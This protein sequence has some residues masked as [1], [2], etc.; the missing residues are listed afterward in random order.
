[1]KVLILSCNTGE[2][3]N[4]SAKAIKKYMDAQ[5]IECDFED[6]LGLVSE[7]VS[8]SV[9]DIYVFSTKSS[10]FE[11]AYRIGAFVSDMET[12]LKS[13]VYITNK[14][15][16]K[17]LYDYIVSGGYDAV[18]CVHLFPAEALT[19]LKRNAKLKVPAIF[20]ATDYTVY[21]LMHETMLDRYVIPHEDLIEDW[22][23][24]GIPR[25]KL[26]PIGIAVDEA[27][28]TERVPKSEARK[29]C[30]EVF[31]WRGCENPD[32]R[33]Y[34]VM[35]GS[36]GFGDLGGLIAELRSLIEEN[37]RVVCVCGR[38]EKVREKLVEEFG[39]KI[40]AIGFT[41]K[42]SMLMDACDVLF[43]KPGGIT[44]TEAIIKNIPFIH[45][46]PIPGLEDYNARFFHY[47][48]MSYSTT[49]VE[50]QARVAVR[51]T[52]DEAYRQRM[53]D[54]QIRNSNPHTCEQIT[55]LVEEM[56]EATSRS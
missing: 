49:D 8:K 13:P 54:A 44:S 50:Q 22:V 19:A 1:M 29:A 36:M 21:P 14:L 34:L 41:D 32:S 11:R 37:D 56:V 25:E 20:V 42:V 9:S 10:L 16:A 38:N 5:G 48:N 18:I 31:G 52:H 7:T 47:H 15:Y 26:V 27:K 35:S 39:D 23:S 2:G 45:T 55:A 46:A 4:S 12:N 24:K 28:F 6:T 53:I 43:S 30:G 40:S 17:K 51:L 33:W 3:H